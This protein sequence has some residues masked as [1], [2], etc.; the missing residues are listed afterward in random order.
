MGFDGRL[1]LDREEHDRPG[2]MGGRVV[3]E[4]AERLR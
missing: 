2:A 4:I 3:D 1:G